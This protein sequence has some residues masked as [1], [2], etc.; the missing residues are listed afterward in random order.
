M[1]A[2]VGA[3]PVACVLTDP[4][5]F[6]E[7]HVSQGTYDLTVDT[8][9]YLDV[10]KPAEFVPAGTTIT[11][12]PVIVLGGDANDDCTVNILDLSFMGAR[13][14][15]SCGD[16]GWDLRADINADCIVNIQDIVLGGS[17]CTKTRPVPW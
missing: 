4:T 9:L 2:W 5:G 3:A 11:L 8:Q 6:Y 17:N 1:C 14:L 13:Y 10:L 16:P 12:P 15:L 7:L